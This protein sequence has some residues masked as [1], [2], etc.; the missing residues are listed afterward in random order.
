MDKKNPIIF[1]FCF[2]AIMLTL[3][4][5]ST[6]A[7]SYDVYQIKAPSDTWVLPDTAPANFPGGTQSNNVTLTAS[8]GEYKPFSLVVHANTDLFNLMV[9]ASNLTS[10]S[11][12]ISSSAVDLRVVKAW[13]RG[14]DA[15]FY[16]QNTIAGELAND[17]WNVEHIHGPG[18]PY[19][20]IYTPELLL[21][22][23]NLIS[24]DTANKQNYMKSGSSNILISESRATWY[25]T[26]LP[27]ISLPGKVVNSPGNIDNGA[28]YYAV[29][30]VTPAGEL[31]AGDSSAPIKIDDKTIAGQV[32]ML[33]ITIGSSDCIARK[34]YR[35]KANAPDANTAPVNSEYYLLATINDNTTSTYTDNTSDAKL[36]NI[37]PPTTP[38]TPAIAPQD[39]STLQATTLSNNQNKQYYGLINIPSNAAP[40][41]YTGTLTITANNQPT[42][43][44]NVTLNVLTTTL[45]PPK[46][47][48]GI[49]YQNILADSNDLVGSARS[50]ANWTKEIQDMAAH[51]IQY[52]G[53]YGSL[54]DSGYLTKVLGIMSAAGLPTDRFY[55]VGDALRYW[56]GVDDNV[57]RAN[58]VNTTLRNTSGWTSAVQYFMS[59]DEPGQTTWDAYIKGMLPSIHATG[60]KIWFAIFGD[61]WN[62]DQ[63]KTLPDQINYTASDEVSSDY[64]NE[65]W[66]YGRPQTGGGRGKP[67]FYRYEY[68]WWAYKN[69]Y[70]GAFP[71]TYQETIRDHT[72]P[73]N[74]FDNF[75]LDENF[76][77]PTTNGMVDSIQWEGFREATYDMR[78]L[79][80]L[81]KAIADSTNASLKTEAQNWLNNL[82]PGD[83]LDSIR[84]T[85][86]DYTTRLTVVAPTYKPEDI[87]Q[88][89]IVNTQ[90]LQ[91]CAN[92][93]LG[94]QSWSRADVNNDGKYDVKDL[95]KIANVIL[96][97]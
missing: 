67:N 12:T 75:V 6:A 42:T 68:G 36:Q 82:N 22:D 48:Y 43:T 85:M 8:K 51:G 38:T 80:T 89:G 35:T 91:A 32:S 58:A 71:Y 62:Y 50:Q 27:S 93:I 74:D 4:P 86:I 52:P 7:S 39:V 53:L 88:D 16:T 31:E 28:H 9:T 83:D 90:D 97:V 44:L 30:M 96:G 19:A 5:E 13:Y 66:L 81:Q 56:T 40:G 47:K 95:Q 21:H 23:D 49:Y 1:S 63:I 18:D 20:R 54:S 14:G 87:N 60:S 34:I 46:L 17:P 33:G 26:P 37:H 76:T 59:S 55:N 77:Y 61:I 69:G 41:T 70:D 25:N 57:N 15:N 72:N 73:W 45:Q 92:Q 94:T 78:Y 24:A 84:A 64:T 79:A 11:N 65:L 3:L 29:T 10:G 2:L